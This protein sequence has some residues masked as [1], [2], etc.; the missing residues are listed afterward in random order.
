M[1]RQSIGRLVFFAKR[2]IK[3]VRYADDFIL[4][5][6]RLPQECLSYLHCMLDKMELT[7]NLDKTKQLNAKK[8]S[9]DF[10]GFTVRYDRS[11]YD[12]PTDDSK[13]YYWNIVPSKKSVK[14][15]RKNIKTCLNNNGH[16]SNY[17]LVKKLN[18]ILRGWSNYF[19]IPKVSYPGRAKDSANTYLFYSLK[20][21]FKR[22]SQRSCKLYRQ[23]AHGK[24]IK[25]YGLYN[26]A[27]RST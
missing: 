4:M 9:F 11:L 13:H 18:P 15:L 8:Q 2:G 14:K 25:Y 10:L 5:G 23:N 3:I 20:R 27:S 1:T 24:L 16:S 21:Y 17:T 12:K 6:Y 19:T 7:V 22:K 26:L